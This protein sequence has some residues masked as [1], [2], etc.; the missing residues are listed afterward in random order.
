MLDTSRLELLGCPACSG[1]L[2]LDAGSSLA[3][4]SCGLRGNLRGPVAFFSEVKEDVIPD[5]GTGYVQERGKWSA[6]RT[7]NFRFF[8]GQMARRPAGSTVIDVGAGPGF[9]PELFEG[10]RYLALDF[11]PYPGIHVVS[12]IVKNRLP[13]RSGSAD[14]VILSN[15]LEH[16]N[17]PELVLAECHRV[18]KEGGELLLT[19]PFLFKIH[20]EPYDFCRYTHFKLKEL[21]EEA[22][23]R[24]ESC[25]KLGTMLDLMGSIKYEY[26]VLA[27]RHT[28]HKWL[29]RQLLRVD[30]HV[31]RVI[32][33]YLA[34]L[35]E[36][37][38]TEQDYF[39]GYALVGRKASAAARSAAAPTG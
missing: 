36:A 2:A 37:S 4:G 12:D 15:V 34:P 9:F 3:C 8:Q 21:V 32:A 13:V 18:L 5:S 24:L 16:L 30:F 22:G 39:V 1:P 35:D 19:V 17:R 6:W 38:L 29:L 25:Q 23:F 33:K 28:R 26:A 27:E 10:H 7:K 11:F 31:N 20:Q 14:V